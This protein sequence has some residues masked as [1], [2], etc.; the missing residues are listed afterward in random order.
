MKL[1]NY[2]HETGKQLQSNQMFCYILLHRPAEQMLSKLYVP[3]ISSIWLGE[4]NWHYMCISFVNLVILGYPFK[5]SFIFP[6]V[7]RIVSKICILH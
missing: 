5:Y 4:Q 6:L 1:G 7:Y 3:K 2:L